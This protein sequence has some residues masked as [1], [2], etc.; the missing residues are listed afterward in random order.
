MSLAENAARID[1]PLLLQ[2]SDNEFRLALEAYAA[3]REQGQPVEMYVYP[4]E[5]H[6]KDQPVHRLAVYQRNLD[7]FSFWLQ[8]REDPAPAKRAQ[9]MRWEAMRA[10]AKA[11]STD[12]PSG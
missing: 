10:R 2:V 9:Y 4:G 3:L 6:T 7:W 1:T 12:A 8:H 5:F 11:K